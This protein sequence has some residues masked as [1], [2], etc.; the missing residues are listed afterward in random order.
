MTGEEGVKKGQAGR[1][2][3]GSAFD[4]DNANYE[5]LNVDGTA[6]ICCSCRPG[7]ASSFEEP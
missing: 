4:D 1:K 7:S 2:V 3:A 6:S 5:R